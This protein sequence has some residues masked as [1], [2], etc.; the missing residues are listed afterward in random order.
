ME[1]CGSW[2]GWTTFDEMAKGEDG[3]TLDVDVPFG[4]HTYK[5]ILD[6]N[7]NPQPSTLNSKP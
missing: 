7:V 5:F 3:F 4:K 1:L 2:S 6:G